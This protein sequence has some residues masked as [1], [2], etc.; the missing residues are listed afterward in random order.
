MASAAK[1]LAFYARAA[2]PSP[3]R[4]SQ[5]CQRDA[6][7]PW[8][9]QRCFSSTPA[10][11]AKGDKNAD[12]EGDQ[13]KTVDHE[14]EHLKQVLGNDL[15]TKGQ[16]LHQIL[17]GVDPSELSGYVERRDRP[18]RAG[19]WME[20]E[21]DMG[22]D[23]EWHGDDITST[24]HAE[25]EQQR[26][27]RE[28]MRIAAWEM[29]LL[30]KYAKPFQPPTGET[31]LRFRYTTYMGEHHPA[32]RKVVVE[33]SVPDMPDLT[34]AQ[35][36]KLIKLA[37]PR[38]NPDTQII[39]MSAEHFETQAQNKRYLGDVIKDLLSEARNPK[40]MFID[41]PFDFRHHK[42]KVFHH[43]PKEW[44]ITPERKKYLEQRWQERLQIDQQKR[45]EGTLVDGNYV[46]E[47]ALANPVFEAPDP[48]M[49][50]AGRPVKKRQQTIGV[51]I[52][53][54]IN[55]YTKKS[56]VTQEQFCR[57]IF[58]M[59]TNPTETTALQLIAFR[60]KKGS[61]GGNTSNV[62]YSAYCFFKKLK[63]KDGSPKS[64]YRE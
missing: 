33:F 54:E 13:A 1:R 6:S 45:E 16:A 38:Y 46:V 56:G 8:Q 15:P 48:L 59:Y 58:D 17:Q 7:T 42:P 10:P 22:E 64:K 37:G 18:A 44:A 26:E 32:E 62:F 14:F 27:I 61:N 35:R 43:F 28:Y 24:G 23:E 11:R 2:R 53:K 31:P 3:L 19:F 41:V 51:K 25:L 47:E 39:K 49:V 34:Q 63:L 36:D 29:P 20:G 21:P 4:T 50:Q 9:P 60:E 57:D 52:R 12:G 55:A 40:D 30:A 5:R